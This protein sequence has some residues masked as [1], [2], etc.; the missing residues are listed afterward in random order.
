MYFREN[1]GKSVVREIINTNLHYK[2]HS[3]ERPRSQ[4]FEASNVYPNP[5]DNLAEL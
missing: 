4:G 1:L 2:R 3:E 5:L